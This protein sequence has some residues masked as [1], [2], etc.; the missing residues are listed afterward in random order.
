MGAIVGY[1]RERTGKSA[2]LRTHMLVSLSSAIFVLA[3]LEAGMN[4]GD[5][6]RVI[7]GVAAGIGFIGAGAIMKLPEEGQIDGLTTAAG[8]W[9]TAG[10]GFGRGPGPLRPGIHQCGAGLGHP[11]HRGAARAVPQLTLPTFRDVRPSNAVKLSFPI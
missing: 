4:P 3:P 9:M 6:S 5:V 1:E 2:G 11:R 8:I 7:Q 10:L